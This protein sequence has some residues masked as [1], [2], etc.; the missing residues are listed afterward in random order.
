[1]ADKILTET[2]L[3]YI[4]DPMCAWCWGFSPI[5]QQVK[6]EYGDRLKIALVLGG[7]R[8]YTKEILKSADR[9]SIMNHWKEVHQMTSQPFQFENAMPDGFIYDTE[10]PSRAVVT[11]AH[12]NPAEIFQFLRTIQHAFYGEGKNTTDENVLAELAGRFG[13]EK[14]DFLH[15]FHTEEMKEKTKSHFIKC[16]QFGVQV[17]PS[18]ILQGPKGFYLLSKGY[19]PYQEIKQEL[20][21][22]FSPVVTS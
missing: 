17:F 18:A 15:R 4:A 1:M 9:I 11:F 20:D 5:I 7:L 12:F 10:I 13:I 16:R 14:N 19:K 3:H 21:D 8:P 22:W 2:I 6:E